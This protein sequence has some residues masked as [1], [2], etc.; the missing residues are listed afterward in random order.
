M[1][2]LSEMVLLGL[3]GPIEIYAATLGSIHEHLL[4][5]DLPP[6]LVYFP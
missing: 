5:C 3:N 2:I 1:A 6:F 4:G